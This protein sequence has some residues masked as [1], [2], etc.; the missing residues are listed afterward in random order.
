[1]KR[2]TDIVDNCSKKVCSDSSDL[3]TVVPDHFFHLGGENYVVVSDFSDV[4]KVHI[5]KYWLNEYGRLI[6]TKTGITLSPLSWQGFANKMCYSG[7]PCISSRSEVIEEELMISTVCIEGKTHVSMQRFYQRKDFIRVFLPTICV[8][9]E[10][11]WDTL[12]SIHKAVTSDIIRLMFGRIFRKM[13]MEEIHK[14]T[15]ASKNPSQDIENVDAEMV[16]TSSLTELFKS[17]LESNISN[18]F[19]C[20]GCINDNNNQLGHDCVC[21]NHER[22]LHRYGDIAIFSMDLELLT[23]EFVQQNSHIVN[24]ITDEFLAK[25]D[26]LCLIQSAKEM[27]VLSDPCPDRLF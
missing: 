25:L 23:K 9:T 22:R 4:I 12:C 26:M 8:L 3:Q 20:S 14:Q 21:M 13:I 15:P 17:H 27:Y 2:S 7:L 11:E 16:L 5:R 1:M 18:V 19:E 10:S 24:Y 6:P